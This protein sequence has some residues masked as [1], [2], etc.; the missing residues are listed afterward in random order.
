MFGVSSNP[1]KEE[2]EMENNKKYLK[3]KEGSIEEAVLKSLMSETPVNPN[4]ARPTLHL[5]KKKY[6]TIKKGS[7]ESA[8]TNVMTETHAPGHTSVGSPQKIKPSWNTK[9]HKLIVNPKGGGVK[10]VT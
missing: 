4:D 1:F 9:T 6:L 3:T 2:T 10:V 7:L 8:V 5:P